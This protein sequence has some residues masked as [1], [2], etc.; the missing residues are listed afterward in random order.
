MDMATYAIGDVQGCYRSLQRLVD[1]IEF[2]S[3]SDR[4]WFVGDVVNRGPESLQV[5]RYIK[6]LGPA[7]QLV[8]GN[9][10]LFL[11][12]A[13]EELVVMRPHDTLKDVLAAT[14]R[15]DL[16]GWLR[17]QPLHHREGSY[18]M[19]HAGLLPQ[20]TVAEADRWARDA[21]AALA[22]P[23]YR[24][25][26]HTLFH[27]A[28]AQWSPALSGFERLAAIVRV[29]TRIRVCTPDGQM[30]AT[31]SGPPGDAPPGYL[32]WFHIPTRKSTDA[33]VIV[34]HWAALG[35]HVT[36]NVVALDSGCVWDGCLTA[37]RLEDRRITQVACVH[38]GCRGD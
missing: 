14:D 31:F 33:T 25:L 29:L 37:M 24:T 34:G 30:A 16:L 2:D 23:H 15:A 19:V 36:H 27:D 7:A 22:G 10:D 9:H 3:A 38:D 12:A 35:L 28:P 5:L 1:L 21:A 6:R 4:L 18:F 13:A 8:L 32:P 17:Q 20:W 11:L 26:L